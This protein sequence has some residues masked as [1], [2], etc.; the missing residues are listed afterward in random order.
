MEQLSSEEM[1]LIYSILNRL[2]EGMLGYPEEV[3]EQ[4][5]Y[6]DDELV[7][8]KEIELL[9]DKLKGNIPPEELERI[10][11]ETMM[12]KYGGFSRSP[13]KRVYTVLE[14]AYKKKRIAGVEYFSPSRE[15]VTQ[16]KIAIYY[17]SRK[18]IIAYCHKRK[19]IRK[20]RADR[21]ISA[22]LNDE[23]YTIPKTFDKKEHI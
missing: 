2:Y 12:E 9:I 8:R 19:K 22:K 5:H 20:F 1:T 15:K 23:K 14:G 21:F 10:D 13:D 18:Y 6:D 4:E 17:L 3:W 7:N 16:R 11:K